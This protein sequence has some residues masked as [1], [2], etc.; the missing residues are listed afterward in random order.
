[1]MAPCIIPPRSRPAPDVGQAATLLVLFGATG[2][3]ALRMLLPSLYG[4]Q[5]DGLLPA[6]LRILG[7]ARAALDDAGFRDLVARAIAQR[8][9]TTALEQASMDALL[10]RLAFQPAAIDD[11]DAMAA[12]TARIAALRSGDVVYH[13]STAPRW[14]PTICE[15]LG[16]AGLAGPGTRVLLEKPIGH[17]LAS[18]IAIN[19]GVAARFDEDR[20]FRVA[21][22]NM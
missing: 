21:T 1:M 7:S 4:L 20:V 9:P 15:R 2:D 19:D 5:R 11:D 17:D 12:L 6:G 14:Y 18:S 10:Q 16:S 8:I 13:L 3:L 22:L